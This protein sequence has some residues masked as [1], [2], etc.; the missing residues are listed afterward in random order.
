VIRRFFAAAGGRWAPFVFAVS[1]VLVVAAGVWY[2]GYVQRQ[3]DERHNQT[4]R[5]SEQ[6]WCA[7]LDIITGGPAPQ[8]GPAGERARAIAAELAKLREGFGCE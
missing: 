6:K 4:V 5:E 1:L 8:P 7:L 2:T 3:A